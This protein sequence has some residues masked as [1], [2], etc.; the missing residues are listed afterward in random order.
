MKIIN[1]FA[2][3][4]K[5]TITCYDYHNLVTQLAL[6]INEQNIMHDRGI[7]IPEELKY[8]I[9]KV[10]NVQADVDGH[11]Q[12]DLPN[13]MLSTSKL[14]RDV[15]KKLRQLPINCK[16]DHNC[17]HVSTLTIPQPKKSKSSYAYRHYLKSHT[18]HT[19]KSSRA[20]H[21]KI[22]NRRKFLTKAESIFNEPVINQYGRKIIRHQNRYTHQLN[23]WID[24][25]DELEARRST[26]W[27]DH[28]QNHQYKM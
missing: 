9:L 10:S 3:I 23:E 27:K 16:K 15:E 18:N 22:R 19:F 17:W 1:Q 26:G 2:I 12:Y 7:S 28:N 21:S 13:T 6:D 24:D 20:G 4:S 11:V 25:W 8:K 5:N 14:N